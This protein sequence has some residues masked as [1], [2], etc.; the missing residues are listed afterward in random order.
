M[1]VSPKEHTTV[2]KPFKTQSTR[3]LP[4]DAEVI[5]HDGKPHVRVKERGR[6]VLCPLTRDGKKYLCPSKCW[7]FEFKDA[8]G[9]VRR[10]KGF[11]DLKATEQA[12]AE[13]ERRVGRI[14]VGLIDPADDH[15]RCPLAEH[16]ADYAE[17]LEAKG[18]TPRHVT[19][20]VGRIASE[21]C[22]PARGSCSSATWNR[23][24]RTSG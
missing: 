5:Q 14:R 23:R 15:L 9:T 6:V 20:T 16:L 13:A 2:P 22:S 7:Y 3:P 10:K 4:P 19:M 12:A 21:R 8:N 18:D 24:R 1:P 17:H 11:T